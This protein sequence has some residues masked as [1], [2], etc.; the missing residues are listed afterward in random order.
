[1]ESTCNNCHG[2]YWQQGKRVYMCETRSIRR[3][4]MC[5]RGGLARNHNGWGFLGD[6]QNANA[7]AGVSVAGDR[8]GK[9]EDRDENVSQNTIPISIPFPCGARRAAVL[10][11]NQCGPNKILNKRHAHTMAS[12]PS[13][14][15]NPTFSAGSVRRKPH[16]QRDTPPPL[17]CTSR[18]AIPSPHDPKQPRSRESVNGSPPACTH[19]SS[20][21]LHQAGF[22]GRVPACGHH[23]QGSQA[24]VPHRSF[25]RV[26]GVME[27][28]EYGK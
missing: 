8:W 19:R 26:L 3:S 22:I 13:C 14:W 18:G 10:G 9:G 2:E 7:D 27:L 17:P 12:R 21:H 23:W 6:E 1:M 25:H 11:S 4:Q 28:M 5:Q 20:T 15:C 24:S 16:Q